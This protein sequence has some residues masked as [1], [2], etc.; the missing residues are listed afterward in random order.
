MAGRAARD[1]AG[2]CLRR[3]HLS[4]SS[5]DL[6]DLFGQLD[7]ARQQTLLAF[8]RFLL[9]EGGRRP[10]AASAAP[11]VIPE[12]EHI[13]RPAQESIVAGLKRLAKTYPMLDKSEMLGATSDLVATSL[14]QGAEPAA[15]IDRLEEIFAQHYQRFRDMR[16]GG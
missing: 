2:G 14:L 3:E 13:E 15:V 4:M 16:Q 10:P 8:A 6:L 12:P 9:T 1:R 11:L 5:R 7:A